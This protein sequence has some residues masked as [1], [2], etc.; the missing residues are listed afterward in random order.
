MEFYQ[1]ETQQNVALGESMI[2]S[3]PAV[4]SYELTYQ[5]LEVLPRPNPNI[6]VVQ[7]ALQV[8]RDGRLLGTIYPHR[9]FF[10]QQEQPMTIPDIFRRS[11]NELYVIIAGWE[12]DGE[13]ATFKAYINP[14]INWLWFG[15][16]VFVFGTLVAAWP[17]AEFS[18]RPAPVKMGKGVVPVK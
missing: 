10:V 4:G 11:S 6:E 16:F 14:L 15:G 3:S 1:V 2:I 5:G 17:E 7:A 8:S 12:G 13:T 18:Q 9:E